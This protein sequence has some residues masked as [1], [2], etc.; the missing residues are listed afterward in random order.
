MHISHVYLKKLSQRLTH[1]TTTGWGH[2]IFSILI[3]FFCPCSITAS[4]LSL[5]SI[6]YLDFQ[7]SIIFACF[8]TVHELR[9]HI[10]STHLLCNVI[11]MKPFHFFLVMVIALDLNKQ[12]KKT[13][14]ICC[15]I[16]DIINY[17]YCVLWALSYVY[18]HETITTS[19]TMNMYTQSQKF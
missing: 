7:N 15:N 6:H 12:T 19:K 18:T 3:I 13:H 14:Q 1:I 17:K 16:I 10:F 8:L 9:I 2:R 5:N 11:F 4:F